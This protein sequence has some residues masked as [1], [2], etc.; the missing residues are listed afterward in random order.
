MGNKVI[1]ELGEVMTAWERSSQGQRGLKQLANS[2]ILKRQY[3]EVVAITERML[4]ME[5]QNYEA[6]YLAAAAYSYLNNAQKAFELAQQVVKIKPDYIGAYMF[7]AFYYGKKSMLREK[8]G[9]L[10]KVVCFGEKLYGGSF[11]NDLVSEAWLQLAI[12]HLALGNIS[13]C[14]KAYLKRGVTEKRLAKKC[15]SYSSYL[16]CSNYDVALS[17]VE[18]LAEHK[19]YNEFFVDI[20][21]YHQV[22]SG[23]KKKLR[24]GYISPDFYEHVVMYFTKPLLWGYNPKKFEVFCYRK[25]ESDEKT[26]QL[27]KAPE[28]RA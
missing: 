8:M 1:H 22:K 26:A 2:Y 27:C 9:M 4:L 19:K 21:P 5:P 10:E 28:W 12:V 25:G 11:E 13:A 18:M 23:F 17:D 24:I 14:K 15:K 20:K 3:K 6:L 7:M 16:M